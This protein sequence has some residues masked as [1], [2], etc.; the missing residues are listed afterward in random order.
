MKTYGAPIRVLNLV[1]KE[2]KNERILGLVFG[3]YMSRLSSKS[4]KILNPGAPTFSSTGDHMNHNSNL[5]NYHHNPYLK[6][7]GI[8]IGQ[9]PAIKTGRRDHSHGHKNHSRNHG[10]GNHHHS[11]H[12]HRDHSQ[13]SH[14]YHSHQMDL[15]TKNHLTLPS[16]HHSKHLDPFQPSQKSSSIYS[17]SSVNSTSQENPYLSYRWFDFFSVYH[18]DEGLL[19]KKMQQFGK[20]YLSDIKPTVIDFSHCGVSTSLQPPAGRDFSSL[21]TPFSQTAS[22]FDPVVYSQRGVIRVNCVDCLD[23][24]NNAM[25]CMASTILAEML[26]KLGV[27]FDN[28]L[29]KEGASVTRELLQLVLDMF[30]VRLC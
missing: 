24:T 23:R 3:K 22:I 14:Q 25:A 11:H 10:H 16:S 15:S 2:S 21:Q 18:Q 5:Q 6:V 20:D 30:G 26:Q 17:N 28:F 27:H 9:S 8:G 4:N 13:H 19:L 12:S 7:S 29:D 1:K